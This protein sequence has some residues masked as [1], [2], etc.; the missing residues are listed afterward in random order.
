[1]SH[2]NIDNWTVV[3]KMTKSQINA[4]KNL[5]KY[6][7]GWSDKG[8]VLNYT[9]PALG[10]TQ[11]SNSK[12]YIVE[13]P[14]VFNRHN[15]IRWGLFNKKYVFQGW[16]NENDVLPKMVKDWVYRRKLEKEGLSSEQIDT[17]I[18]I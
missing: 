9:Y 4:V 14:S 13:D 5:G 12:Y 2:E 18:K 6:S 7:A 17:V 16:Y 3:G 1:M 10:G 15:T 8:Y 11:Y